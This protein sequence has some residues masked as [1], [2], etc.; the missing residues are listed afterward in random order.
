MSL[1]DDLT[2]LASR[3]ARELRS[4]IDRDRHLLE[5]RRAEAAEIE[6]RLAAEEW[7]LE[8]SAEQSPTRET[9]R[10]IHGQVSNFIN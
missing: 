8:S 2:A 6:R 1:D 7:L 4:R 5:E 9:L 3:H 10:V